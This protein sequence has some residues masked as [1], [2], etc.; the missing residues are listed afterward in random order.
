MRVQAIDT[1]FRAVDST[2]KLELS[3]KRSVTISTFKSN[4][5]VNIREYYDKNGELAPGKKGIALD[6]EQW[7]SLMQKLPILQQAVQ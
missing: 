6:V 7:A 5:F 4:N 3:N 2:Y 1:A